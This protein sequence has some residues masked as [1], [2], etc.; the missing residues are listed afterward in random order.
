MFGDLT[1][2]QSQNRYVY[3]RNNPQKYTDPD[4]RMFLVDDLA[5]A[6]IAGIII[7]A[8]IDTGL[9]L[10]NTPRSN[11]N[12]GDAVGT[13]VGGAVKGGM[14]AAV[15]API[16]ASAAITGTIT[17]TQLGVI[18]VGSM[19]A[20]STSNLIEM[21]YDTAAGNDLVSPKENSADILAAGITSSVRYCDPVRIAYG[22]VTSVL[23]WAPRQ[24]VNKVVWGEGK[25]IVSDMLISTYDN[26][27]KYDPW[28]EEYYYQQ[29]KTI[30]SDWDSIESRR[31]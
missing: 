10:H 16:V 1:D 13:F 25:S 6:I 11:W 28:R 31:G 15:A 19:L 8:V 20:E 23:P 9:Y 26:A 21:I 24:T 7:G 18:A 17:A 27:Q 2:P 3:C 29:P 4:G 5:A 14:V 30:I 22:T 12:A